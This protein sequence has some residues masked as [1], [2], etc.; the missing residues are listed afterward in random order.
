MTFY[1]I[2]SCPFYNSIPFR[3]TNFTSYHLGNS[4]KQKL[5][6]HLNAPRTPI[7]TL[8]HMKKNCE[9]EKI[10]YSD[11]IP[12]LYITCG[13]VQSMVQVL[14][15]PRH[16]ILRQHRTRLVTPAAGH[17]ARAATVGWAGPF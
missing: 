13:P 5:I 6:P 16:L 10:Q 17:S 4:F 15:T 7:I 11:W 2:P 8:F 14:H 1:S 3:I 12:G 9:K